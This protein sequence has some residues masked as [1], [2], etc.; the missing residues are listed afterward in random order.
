MWK[1]FKY[2][3]QIW[4]TFLFLNVIGKVL[5]LF[6]HHELASKLDFGQLS[7]V[8]TNGLGLDVSIASYM[9][10]PV[11]LL[12]LLCHWFPS[13]A[14]KASV[15]YYFMVILSIVALVIVADL[16]LF[17][18]WGFKIEA[19]FLRFADHPKE[20][21]ASMQSSPLLLLFSLFLGYCIVIYLA[22]KR[23]F[24]SDYYFDFKP[25][26][27][28]F[29]AHLFLLAFQII[30]IRGGLQLAPIN[31]SS[32]YFSVNYFANQSAVNPCFNFFQS[33]TKSKVKENPF[34]VVAH[35][36]ALTIVD[37][38][39]K[40]TGNTLELLNGNKP[41]MLIVTW[42]SMTAKLVG[43][44]RNGKPVLP[45]FEKLRREGVYFENCFA[46]GD[47]SPKGIVAILSGYPAQPITSIIDYPN[48]TAKLPSISQSLKNEGYSTAWYYGGEPEFGNMKSYILNIGF[49]KLV[50]K[51]DFTDAETKSTKWGANDKKVFERLY[52]D[53]NKTTQ[54]FFVNYFTLS[55]HEP[56]EVPNHNVI[57][58]QD[59]TSQFLNAH[60]YTDKH[61]GEFIRKAKQSSWWKN[62]VIIVI[63]DHGHPQPIT[64][65]KVEQF[66]VPMLWL[67]GALEG[68]QKMVKSVCSQTDLVK[69]LLNQLKINTAKFIWSKDIFASDYKPSAYFSFNNGFGWVNASGK[70]VFDNVGKQDIEMTPGF[71]AKSQQL[72]KV[73]QQAS[74][75]DFLRK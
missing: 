52:D 49:D 23:I 2:I 73:Y 74:F 60:N 9:L 7:G 6:Y 65:H 50:T 66:V 63:A 71:S 21:L 62:T 57:T 39:N 25:K 54:P 5:F 37:S 69:T 51:S 35:Q 12:H 56:F 11:I 64:S 20:M 44:K 18:A 43:L 16:E 14:L 30:P 75:E 8:F 29:C 45:E 42:E 47:R 32:A 19:S 48:K 55:S 4:L 67:G 10:A 27:I 13:L 36:K 17:K 34:V 22:Q 15:K 38:L 59:E 31:Q 26:F 33:L 70:L 3:F 24:S 40:T 46:S 1:S 58:G 41:N 53:L 28:S 72:G 61:F 68:K